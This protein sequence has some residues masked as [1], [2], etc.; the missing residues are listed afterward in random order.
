MPL[1]DTTGQKWKARNCNQTF[2][3]VEKS[4]MTFRV[5]DEK[6]DDT[7]HVDLVNLPLQQ[8]LDKVTIVT[9]TVLKPKDA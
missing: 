9:L 1:R 3:R 8:D 5:S 2:T 6:N 4:N 7:S